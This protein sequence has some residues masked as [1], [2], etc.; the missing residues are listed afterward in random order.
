MFMRS[1][2]I[3]FL[4]WKQIMQILFFFKQSIQKLAFFSL[5]FSLALRPVLREFPNLAEEKSS[6]I[7]RNKEAKNNMYFLFVPGTG[8][9]SPRRG[10]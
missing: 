8:N 2:L 3:H 1:I 5:S 7:N 9:A 4:L 10:N 6:L